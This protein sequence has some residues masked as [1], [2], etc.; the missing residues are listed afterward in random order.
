MEARVQILPL[1]QPTANGRIY[2]RGVVEAALAKLS[3]Q[4]LA[5]IHVNT[6]LTKEGVPTVA[7]SLGAA[8]NLAID[9]ATNHVLANVSIPVIPEDL[10]S[11][12]V[13]RSAGFGTLEGNTVTEFT[14]SAVVIGRE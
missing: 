11:G 3:G 5:V 8:S 12:F 10:A 2:P 1:D 14:I 13:L 7:D 6:F 4:V 9:D